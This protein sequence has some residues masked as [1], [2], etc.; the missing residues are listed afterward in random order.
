[1]THRGKTFFAINGIHWWSRNCLPFRSTWL[2]PKF[3]ME[4][5]LLDL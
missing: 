3:L 1:M 5:V 4:F 2:H